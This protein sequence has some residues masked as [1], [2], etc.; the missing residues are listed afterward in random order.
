MAHL[1][2]TRNKAIRTLSVYGLIFIGSL[3][4][5]ALTGIATLSP[6][7]AIASLWSIGAGAALPFL[8]GT[9][10]IK[11]SDARIIIRPLTA[12][13][14]LPTKLIHSC[15]AAWDELVDADATITADATYFKQGTKSAKFVVAANLAA[16]DIVGTDNFTAVDLSGC[17]KIGFWFRSSVALSAGD[18]QI[19]LDNTA[20]CASPLESL[21]I[22][23]VSAGNVNTWLYMKINLAAASG[24]TAIV[25]VGLKCIV[26]VPGTFYIDDIRG[27]EGDAIVIPFVNARG[28]GLSEALEK[29]NAIRSGRQPQKPTGG[30]ITGDASMQLEL[31]P[32]LAVIFKHLLGTCATTDLTGSKYQHD[33]TIG[34]LGA[35]LAIEVQHTV[36]GKYRVYYIKGNTFSFSQSATGKLMVDTTWKVAGREDTTLNTTL[37]GSPTDYGH[38]PFSAKFSVLTEGVASLTIATSFKIDVNNSTEG[39]PTIGSEGEMDSLNEGIA[40]INFNFDILYKDDTQIDKA[41]AGTETALKIENSIGTG[42]GTS[43]NEYISIETKECLFARPQDAIDG[44]RG[45]KLSFTGIA[46]YDNDAG[47]QAITVTFKNAQSSIP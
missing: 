45:L 10:Q 34:P 24:D 36:A 11:G 28:F 37:D 14:T 6:E 20:Q 3:F 31:N 29:S 21:D 30:A 46:Y 5:L 26:D 22:P 1:R 39:E 4:L 27:L 19:L 18:Y 9:A 2:R 33:I 16:G 41:E 32:Y 42:V 38:N 40:D 44:P 43:G 12:E 35:G 23:A 47:A 15:E 13:K 7:A 17:T 8:F 25:S